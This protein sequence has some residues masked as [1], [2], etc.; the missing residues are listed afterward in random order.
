[1]RRAYL[2]CLALAFSQANAT[3]AQEEVP[4]PFVLGVQTHF[5]QGWKLDLLDPARAL[6]AVALRDEISWARVEAVK[7]EYDFSE[8]DRYMRPLIDRKFVPLIVIN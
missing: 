5:S 3:F 4:T 7:G 6:G 2:Y 1:M 8:A